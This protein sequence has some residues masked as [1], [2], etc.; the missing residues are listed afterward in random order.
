MR[1]RV[2]D[3]EL[4]VTGLTRAV[5]LGSVTVLPLFSARPRRRIELLLS[6]PD[7]TVA[8]PLESAEVHEFLQGTSPGEELGQVA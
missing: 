8:L 2:F 4:L 5:G 6:T 3:R 7:D 1:R